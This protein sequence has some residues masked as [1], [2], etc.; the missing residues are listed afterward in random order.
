MA[1]PPASSPPVPASLV[2]TN[3]GGGIDM[4]KAGDQVTVTFTDMPTPQQPINDIVKQDGTITLLQNQT[5]HVAGKSRR[6][7]E[8]EIHDFYVPDYYK[9]MSVSIIPV[10]A[11]RFYYVDGEVKVPNRQVYI[12]PTTVTKAISSAGGFTDFANKT[13]IILTREDGRKITVNWKKAIK[14]PKADLPIY[15]NDSIYVKRSIM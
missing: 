4:L 11:T 13:S 3:E 7:V 2:K 14:D 6:E 10:A 15:P 1:N 9:N 5:F 8:M 12:G